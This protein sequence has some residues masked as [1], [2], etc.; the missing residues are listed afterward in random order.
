M[1]RPAFRI[2]RAG[3][4][5]QSPESPG[6]PGRSPWHRADRRPPDRRPGTDGTVVPLPAGGG[7]LYEHPSAPKVR[8]PGADAPDL[9]RRGR[10]VPGGGAFCSSSSRHQV[11]ERPGLG[12][13]EARR[14]P[15]GNGAEFRRG[16]RLGDR[17]HR[18]QLLPEGGGF[19]PGNPGQSLLPRHGGWPGNRPLPGRR[20]HDGGAVGNGRLPVY[21]QEGHAPV[22]PGKLRH[23]REGNFRGGRGGKSATG[24]RW[25]WT[26]RA[27]W[28]CN[29][30]IPTWKPSTPGRSAFGECTGMSEKLR[31][32]FQFIPNLRIAF[33]DDIGYTLLV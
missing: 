26:T 10:H 12:K 6:F 13:A 22:L 11:D 24:G 7:D 29:F 19:S 30:P 31:F 21:R 33:F 8:P 25:T 15:H 27:R 3:F 5:Q 23:P 32:C 16:R 2:S 20:R 28:W 9:R 14:N 4:H 17:G 1:E 18:R